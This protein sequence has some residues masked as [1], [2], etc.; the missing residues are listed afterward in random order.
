MTFPLIG[1]NRLYFLSN[2]WKLIEIPYCFWYNLSRRSRRAAS[3]DL[4]GKGVREMQYIIS[5][6][7]LDVTE[8]IRNSIYSKMSKLERY[9]T[10]STE[11]HVTLSVEKERQKIEVT[12]PMKGSIIRAEE[13]S[14]DMYA[15]IDMV[16]DVIERQLRKYKNKIIQKEQAGGFLQ[17]GYLDGEEGG[18]DEIRIV[19]RKT[20]EVKPMDV[21]EACMQ[22]DLL[23][24]SFYVFRN[25]ETDEINVVYRRK[26]NSYGLIEPQC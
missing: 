18:D 11:V 10:E 8:G 4:D 25:A 22:M 2:P 5:G 20:F 12:I 3:L 21:E 13:V 14:Q 7:N 23:N 16:L 17:E 26:G 1:K 15:S 6:K 19:R 24:H 9:F